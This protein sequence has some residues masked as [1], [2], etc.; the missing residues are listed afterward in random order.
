VPTYDLRIIV[1]FDHQGATVA[2]STPSVHH[3][4]LY[5]DMQ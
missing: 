5:D 2:L 1:R 3:S 4:Y